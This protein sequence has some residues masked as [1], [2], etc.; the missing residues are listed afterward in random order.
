MAS[1]RGSEPR[2]DL[3]DGLAR[4][5]RAFAPFGLLVPG[6]RS[7]RVGV[8]ARAEEALRSGVEAKEEQARLADAAVALSQSLK[9]ANQYLLKVHALNEK[10]LGELLSLRET[11]ELRLAEVRQ[12]AETHLDL[13]RREDEH[14]KKESHH[15]EAVSRLQQQQG[16]M[17]TVQRDVQGTLKDA[18]SLQQSAQGIQTEVN[19]QSDDL[20]HSLDELGKRRERLEEFKAHILAREEA[21]QRNEAQVGALAQ[22][23]DGLQAELVALK[24]QAIDEVAKGEKLVRE[25]EIALVKREEETSAANLLQVERERAL[26]EREKELDDRETSLSHQREALEAARAECDARE[27]RIRELEASL[28]ALQ[29]QRD[30]LNRLIAS[31]SAKL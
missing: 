28:Q 3:A 4:L 21:V 27:R 2:L 17:V 6:L 20:A 19:R 25:R 29:S 8:L 12:A 14:R 26:R 15:R 1:D 23:R 10:H 5:Q 18:H 11:L 7:S 22:Q 13:V 31:M 9:S 16:E 30:E 24:K